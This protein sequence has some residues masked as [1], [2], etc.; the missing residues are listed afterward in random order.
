MK[1]VVVL[2]SLACAFAACKPNGLNPGAPTLKNLA[3]RSVLTYSNTQYNKSYE[4]T[5]YD[6][7]GIPVTAKTSESY[8]EG[9][10]PGGPYTS[11]VKVDYDSLLR[12]KKT[13][14]TYNQLGYS[15]CCQSIVFDPNRQ[16]INEYEYQ[17]NTTNVTHEVRYTVDVKKGVGL[18]GAP[19]VANLADQEY[20]RTFNNQGQ[21]TQEKKGEQIL[22][23]VVYDDNHN[24]VSETLY[25]KQP[26]DTPAFTRR[27]DNVYDQNKN[28]ISRKISGSDSFETNTYD[29]Q[30][31]LIRR[32][33]NLTPISE[34]ELLYEN[35][36]TLID[37]SFA[38]LEERHAMGFS[39]FNG[40]FTH[41]AL[42]V[43]TYTYAGEETLIT[44]TTYSFWTEIPE[45]NLPGFDFSG[46][47]KEKLYK[48]REMKSQLNKWNKLTQ[49][50]FTHPYVSD[51]VQPENFSAAYAGSYTYT[52]DERGNLT[53][54]RGKY[55]YY[56]NK[57]TFIPN[58]D[59][60][61]R[62]KN[63]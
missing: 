23:E 16:V 57:E 47:P 35:R 21:L 46:L 28:L 2:F 48:I 36:G 51:R 61:A 37:Y 62:Y 25:P 59:F 45:A 33:T 34:Y 19:S 3:G 42:R 32:V 60:D 7:N 14:Q 38:R 54:G 24:V 4:V 56:I 55:S 20:F 26:G 58:P 1:K 11:A 13:T 40:Q 52:Y 6:G 8:S 10:S 29:N 49:E 15:S 12:P 30:G 63:F 31:R 5:E 41:D 17:G 44:T 39:Y 22:Y 53:R 18:T 9:F 43:L 50:D 27:W